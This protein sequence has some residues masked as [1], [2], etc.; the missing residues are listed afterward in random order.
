MFGP[1][2]AA[3]MQAAQVLTGLAMALFLAVGVIP[4]FRPYARKIQAVVLAAYLLGGTAFIVYALLL[5]PS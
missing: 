4:G 5:R 3:E 1:A 2:S